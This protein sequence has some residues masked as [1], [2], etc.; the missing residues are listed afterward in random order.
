MESSAE[1]EK[2]AKTLAIVSLVTGILGLSACPGL[3]S[4]IAL[5]TGILAQKE[6]RQAPGA[7]SNR[8]M[9]VAGTVLGAIGS[10][11]VVLAVGFIL[12]SS[13]WAMLM[14][15]RIRDIFGSVYSSLK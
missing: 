9:A 4:A 7:A 12:L 3:G 14:G 2:N 1:Q 5:A 11:L 13:V 6:I 10:A 15:P 8:G